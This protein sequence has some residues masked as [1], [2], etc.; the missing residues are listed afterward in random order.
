MLKITAVYTRRSLADLLGFQ[1]RV[2]E[3][4]VVQEGQSTFIPCSIFY[5]GTNWNRSTP[6]WGYWFKKGVNIYQDPAVATNDPR[7][8]VWTDTRERFQLLG[9]PKADNCSL[10]IR[11]AQRSDTGVYFFRVERGTYVQYNYLKNQLCVFVTALT[12]TPDIH[13]VGTLESG[14][15]G[16]ITCVVQWPCEQGV[17]PTFSW[18]RV[19]LTSFLGPQTPRSSVLTLSPQVSDHG[20]HLTCQVTFPRASVTVP[21]TVQLNVSYAPQNMFIQVFRANST[22]PPGG[23]LG[24]SPKGTTSRSSSKRSRLPAELDAGKF[25]LERPQT[26]DSGVLELH[27]V[28]A[29]YGGEFTC[30]AEH[31]LGSRHISLSLAVQGEQELDPCAQNGAQDYWPVV[32]T[33]LR[34]TL[35]GI[36]FVLTYGLTRLYYTRCAGF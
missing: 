16:N 9:D 22:D 34:G 13:I 17:P 24:R 26:L 18:I 15:P 20:T 12:E 32:L 10:R 23:S 36:G 2:P 27:W 1:L 30:W 31:P 21:R 7:R 25:H 3:S 5:P 33:L 28:A 4:V 19:N 29:E 11:D 35:M 8:D 14:H 6:A